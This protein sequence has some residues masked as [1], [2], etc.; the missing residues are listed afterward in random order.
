M[1]LNPI[2]NSIGWADYSWNPFTGCMFL[3]KKPEIYCY[4]DWPENCMLGIT[5]TGLEDYSKVDGKFFH[6]FDITIKNKRFI[7]YEPL[8]YNVNIPWQP[9]A[10]FIVGAM[11]G[12]NAVQP[13]KEWIDSIRNNVPE[14]KIFW[15][16]NI[17]K[18]ITE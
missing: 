18:Y 14:E 8:L 11:S 12:K 5:L 10:L 4:F 2:K 1:S 7:S 9:I 3:T 16:K 6:F 17:L 13:K 15:K